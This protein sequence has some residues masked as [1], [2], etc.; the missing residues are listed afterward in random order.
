MREL[1]G[2]FLAAERLGR[3]AECRGADDMTSGRGADGLG[4]ALGPRE[5][6]AESNAK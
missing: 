1:T 3:A 6:W 2:S 4:L 5:P